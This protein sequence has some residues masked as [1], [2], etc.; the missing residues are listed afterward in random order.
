[1]I[2][3][4]KLIESGVHF[5][6]QKSKWNP[7]MKPYIWGHKN[8]VHLID[9]F[10][11]AEELE[12]AS[13]FLESVVANGETIL[14]VGTKKAAQNGIT[15]IA[16]ELNLPYVNNRW[17]GGTFS[18]FR[19]VKKSVANY[20]HFKDILEKSN[21]FNYTKKELNIIQKKFDRLAKNVGGIVNLS[22][23]IGAVLVVDVKKE[24][25]C[26]KEAV[27]M[28]IPIVALVDTN[29]DPSNID[30][31]IPAND[32]APR[33]IELLLNYIAENIK[34]GQE[35][36]KSKPKEEFNDQDLLDSIL[37]QDSED[38]EDENSKKSKGKTVPSKGPKKSVKPKFF[39][40]PKTDE[41]LEAPKDN[42]KKAKT[43]SVESTEPSQAE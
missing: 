9:V 42:L 13:K 6:H 15:Q 18:N 2:D 12:R 8:N 38:E 39:K 10:K 27:S 1:M 37:A 17:I 14:L 23:P 16:K 11:T 26:V 30:Y 32:D 20:L 22:W 34:K 28:S 25:V 3:K 35:V 31:V 21:E 5:G 43:E 24:H 7:K 29:G 19:Q 36:A 41:D 33:S 4:R 40:K